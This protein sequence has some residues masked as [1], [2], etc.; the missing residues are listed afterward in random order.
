MTSPIVSRFAPAPTGRL[1]LGHVLNAVHVW[2]LVRACAG[3]V[4][5]RVE[6]HDRR[7]SRPEFETG[8]LDDLEWLGFVPD[9]PSLEAFRAGTCEGRQSNRSH[10]YEAALERLAGGAGAAG[11]LYVCECSRSEIAA[12][13]TPG[14]ELRYPGT[15][16]LKGLR[17]RPGCGLRVRLESTAERFD[18]LRHGWVEQRPFEQCGDLLV[19]D[20]DGCWTYQ[21]AVAVDDMEQRVNLVVRG[22]DLL[23]SAGRQ[24][25]LARLLGRSRPVTFLHHPLIMKSPTQK[26][27]KAD[28]DTSVRDLRQAGWSAAM[29]IGK[30][31]QLGGLTDGCRPLRVDDVTSIVGERYLHKLLDC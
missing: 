26:L 9:D 30:A 13:S 28:G 29:V 24:I 18:D 1:H 19:R 17:D 23:A 31:A 8:L 12:A 6:D 15:C 3:R 5:L 10:V 25:H 4:L 20:R 2:G 21:F 22:D 14:D 27:S 7:R 11:R 16:A